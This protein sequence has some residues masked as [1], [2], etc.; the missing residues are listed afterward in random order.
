MF[1]S[2]HASHAHPRCASGPARAQARDPDGGRL[3]RSAH[4]VTQRAR[5]CP[6]LRLN[7]SAEGAPHM[8]RYEAAPRMHRYE[9]APRMYRYE[10]ALRMHRY[11]AAPRMHH[12]EAAPCMHRW[13]RRAGVAHTTRRAQCANTLQRRWAQLALACVGGAWGLRRRRGPPQDWIRRCAG[14]FRAPR[15]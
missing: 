13:L 5:A 3:D 15:A 9:A 7:P 14:R 11:E 6:L 12:Y 4:G 8:H 10:A 1:V 2:H